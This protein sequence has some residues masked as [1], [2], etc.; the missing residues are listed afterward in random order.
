MSWADEIEAWTHAARGAGRRDGTIRLRT[1][2]LR[3]FADETGTQPYATTPDHISAWLAAHRWQ[4]ETRQSA[5]ASL[6]VFYRWAVETERTS[7]DPA[8][9]TGRI[10]VPPGVPRPAPSASHHRLLC[11]RQ[12]YH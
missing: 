10:R 2:Y 1:Y 4:P 9:V 8:R 7:Y 11:A 5:R 3:L 12:W 6:C